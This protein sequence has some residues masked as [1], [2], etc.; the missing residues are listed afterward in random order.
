V[1]DPDRAPLVLGMFERYSIGE[2]LNAKGR[3]DHAR[4][5][6]ASRHGA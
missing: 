1:P 6:L 2:W 3:D 4:Q 5:T